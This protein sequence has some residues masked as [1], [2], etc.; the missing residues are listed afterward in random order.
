MKFTILTTGAGGAPSA[1][2]RQ[3]KSTTVTDPLPSCTASMV[4]MNVELAPRTERPSRRAAS[5]A[6]RGASPGMPAAM[7]NAATAARRNI[8]C[9]TTAASATC[10]WLDLSG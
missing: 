4:F 6:V 5:P 9:P 8:E 2:R 10:G 1:A 7:A 3:S